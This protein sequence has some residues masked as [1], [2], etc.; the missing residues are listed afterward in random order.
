MSDQ[1]AGDTMASPI[2]ARSDRV[3][4]RHPAEADRAEWLGLREQSRAFHEPWEPRPPA[5][6]SYSGD[7][8]FDRL[9]TTASTDQSQRHLICRL[10]DGAILG[11]VNLSQITGEPFL[12]AVMGY[13]IGEPFARQGYASEGV[14]LCLG[15]A[16]GAL[17]L[18]RV[19]ANVIPTNHASLALV[20]RV[21]FRDEGYSLR[22]LQIAG[23]W[24]DH[25]RWAMTIE[26]WQARGDA[27]PA[28]P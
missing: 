3:C 10:S 15:R 14:V 23:Q 26:D 20:R 22:Y 19:E 5:G 2:L 18:H 28:V 12:N 24:A 1:Q 21:G 4:L 17:G 13:W 27:A 16:F 6:V 25:T 8:G 9:L 7:A 11:M